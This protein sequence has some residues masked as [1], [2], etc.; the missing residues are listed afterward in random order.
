MIA[1]GVLDSTLHG[2]QAISLSI[3]YVFGP[4]RLDLQAIGDFCRF[5]IVVVVTV[6]GETT[7]PQ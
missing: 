4:L 6:G 7:R 2:T 3:D 1:I 5:G